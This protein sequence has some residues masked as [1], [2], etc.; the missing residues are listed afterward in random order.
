MTA[1]SHTYG[2]YRHLM[3]HLPDPAFICQAGRV[4]AVNPVAL[5]A[6]QIDTESSL[7][8]DLFA[9]LVG[10]DYREVFEA[11]LDVIAGEGPVP[12]LLLRADGSHMECEIRVSPLGD[13]EDLHFVHAR[14]LTDRMRAIRDVMASEQRYRALVD[15]ALDAMVVISG[16]RITMVN[17]SATQVLRLTG[18]EQAVGRP[19]AD[20]IHPDYRALLDLGLDALSEEPGLLT[21]KLLTMDGEGLDAEARVVALPGTRQF[22]L[23]ARDISARVRAAEGVR[24]REARLQGI[25][26]TVADAIVTTDEGGM[27]Q[28]FNAAAERMF[29][30]RAAEVIGTGISRLM[31]D[32]DARNGEQVACRTDGSVFP[33]EVSLST[34]RLGRQ[35]L[36]T[37][38]IRDITDRKRA[39]EA[40]RRYTEDLERQVDERTRDLMRL[41]RESQGVLNAAGDGIV[42]I[43]PDGVVTFANPAMGDLLGWPRG[44]LIGLHAAD[45]FRHGDG[46]RL[47][48]PVRVRAALRRGVFHDRVE[49]TLMR[50]DGTTFI[51]EYTSNPILG[52][53]DGADPA[54][55]SGAVV[56]VRDITERRMVEERLKIA[57]TVFETT[58]EGIL[59]CGPEGVITIS[60][61]AL[62]RIVGVR[63]KLGATADQTLFVASDFGWAALLESLH[64][65]GHCEAE[66]W[67]ERPNGERFAARLAASA[68]VAPGGE[69]RHVVLV[70]N[71]ITQRKLDE[72][73][74]RYQA[75]YDS[76]T[77]LPNRALFVDRLTQAVRS[78]HRTGQAMALMFIDLDGFKAVN[79]THG[80][81]V[82]DILLKE[83]GRRLSGCVRESDTVARL[84]GD[85]FTI[86]MTAIDGPDCARQVADRILDR[87]SAPFDLGDEGG[88]PR[89]G[90]VSASIGIAL[91]PAQAETAE[92]LLRLADAAMY[93]AKE[94]GKS[95][96]VISD[97]DSGMPADNSRSFGEGVADAYT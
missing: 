13:A 94:Q 4:I 77:G 90:R 5:K 22:V 93:R 41:T 97:G 96:Y 44:D 68:I 73:R 26:N 81:D 56:V 33:A 80:H 19:V 37:G 34:L 64:Q 76:L 12:M 59:V 85:E 20:I 11:G 29:G 67:A 89:R 87:L 92:D 52:G 17:A 46:T 95:R 66:F 39:E 40:E 1:L 57:A 18:P 78:L 2:S 8:G 51:A 16:G 28:S 55:V 82:G 24:E 91:G 71:D 88:V 60:N 50:R 74:I 49:M 3:A 75:N 21:L 27:L 61:P 15:L 48:S 14:D 45:V 10:G 72:E 6:L 30:L 58:A 42:G 31:P 32:Y 86:I 43:T 54:L 9:C 7:L 62:D 83:A 69:L 63:A 35:R 65:T 38:V 84:G 79:D 23:E 47:G 25:L 36:C 70:V 53:D